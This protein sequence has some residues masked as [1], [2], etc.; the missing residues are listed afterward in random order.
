MKYLLLLGF[1]FCS[2]KIIIAQ[3]LE[4]DFV[5]QYL[6][7]NIYA[8]ATSNYVLKETYTQNKSVES[9][10]KKKYLHLREEYDTLGRSFLQIYYDEKGDMASK[11]IRFYP[12]PKVE[13]TVFHQNGGAID[14]V[15]YWYN[16]ANQRTCEYWTWGA[17][18]SIDTV[19]YKYNTEQQLVAIYFNY[20]GKAKRDSFLYK[21]NFL[22]KVWTFNER[23]ELQRETEFFYFEEKLLKL[24]HRNA[25]RLILQEEFFLYNTLGKL[26]RIIVKFYEEQAQGLSMNTTHIEDYSYY[27]EGQLKEIRRVFYNKDKKKIGKKIIAYNTENLPIYQFVQNKT[28]GIYEKTWWHFTRKIKK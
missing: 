3:T 22:E 18:K 6:K 13:K 25:K 17:N 4:Q 9:L 15:V 19:L 27:K 5:T 10:Y 7:I 24:T 11:I 28:A 14:S 21:N 2:Y 20:L 12:K 1:L 16:D 23:E 26:Q 8:Q